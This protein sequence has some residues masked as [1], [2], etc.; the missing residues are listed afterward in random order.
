MSAKDLKSSDG[1]P[2]D[3]EPGACDGVVGV[4]DH[5]H[6]EQIVKEET[7]QVILSTSKQKEKGG[8]G[9]KGGLTEDEKELLVSLA[10]DRGWLH[11][12]TRLAEQL[13]SISIH[14]LNKIYCNQLHHENYNDQIP[15]DSPIRISRHSRD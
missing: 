8:D 1:H 3:L 6:P 9:Q 11:R 7:F 5:L 15:S 2:V 4:E 12:P 14:D 13:L 10:G